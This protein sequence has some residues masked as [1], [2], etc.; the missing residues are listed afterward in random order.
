LTNSIG[1]TPNVFSITTSSEIIYAGTENN[2]V[3]KS[4]D[5]GANWTAINN[6]L[7]MGGE[8]DVISMTA[9]GSTL[10]AGTYGWGIYRSTDGGNNWTQTITGLAHQVVESIVFLGTDV[11]CSHWNGISKST[12]N[13]N[14]WVSINTIATGVYQLSVVGNTI[15][16]GGWG[17]IGVIKSNDGGQTWTSVNNGISDLNIRSL[18]ANE[19]I[20]VAGTQSGA[21][22]STDEG[23]SWTLFNDGFTNP[24]PD[25]QSL[26]IK[27]NDLFAGSLYQ[28]VWKRSDLQIEVS[29]I[30]DLK[31]STPYAIEL[32]PNYPNPTFGNTSISFEMRESGEVSLK[33]YNLIGDE[34][35]C[36]ADGFKPAGKYILQFNTSYLAAGVYIYTLT[37]K[38][39]R[40]SKRM[41]VMK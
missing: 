3:Y 32:N 6:G 21:F 15:Y 23:A 19:N 5:N 1:N 17:S 13:G 30:N 24:T 33:V 20:L 25:I 10:F 16:A 38:N 26:I 37:S 2:G 8:Q 27:N 36:L 12:D 18:V 9:S 40:V 28:S 11:Y 22:I 7:L 41:N 29:S 35:V 4:I 31:N 34:I 39:A 14:T